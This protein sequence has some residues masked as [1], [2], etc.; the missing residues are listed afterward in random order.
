SDNPII[1]QPPANILE[2]E[3]SSPDDVYPTPVARVS[4]RL[5]GDI[6]LRRRRGRKGESER[7]R[8]KL[9]EVFTLSRTCTRSTINRDTRACTHYVQNSWQNTAIYSKAYASH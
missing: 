1:R 2:T 5:R 7:E 3:F 4:T 8:T 6:V 9:R